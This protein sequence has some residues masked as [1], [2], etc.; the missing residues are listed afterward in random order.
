[1]DKLQCQICFKFYNHLGSHVAG[2]HGILAREYKKQFGINV[3]RGLITE[4][5][6]EKH[7]ANLTP[8]IIANLTK[9]GESTRYKPGEV[10]TYSRSDETKERLKHQFDDWHLKFKT[11]LEYRAKVLQTYKGRRRGVMTE[12]GR[13]RISEAKKLYWK[14]RRENEFRRSTISSI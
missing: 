1:M 8:E 11:D 10:P 2:G 12:E 9:L 6:K 14:N 13:K 5:I 4:E 3:K 7:R